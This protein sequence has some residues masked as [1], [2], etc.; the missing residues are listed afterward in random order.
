MVQIDFRVHFQITCVNLS[1]N[2]S[3]ENV[4][5]SEVNFTKTKE[6]AGGESLPNMFISLLLNDISGTQVLNTTM[7]NIIFDFCAETTSTPDETTYSEV[8]IS[9]TKSPTMSVGK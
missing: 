5:Y 8:K 3:E 7:T 1:G 2:M 9:K 4:V 6:K